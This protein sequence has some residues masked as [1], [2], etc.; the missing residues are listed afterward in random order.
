MEDHEQ[1]LISRAV[2]GKQVEEFLASEIGQYLISCAQ[3]RVEA[4]QQDFKTVDC[5]DSAKVI[6]IQN[7]ILVADCVIQW[8]KDAVGD[9]VRALNILDN[10]E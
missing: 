6:E 10:G 7:R 8:L 3:D 9:G 5:T 4:A 2:F 1:E